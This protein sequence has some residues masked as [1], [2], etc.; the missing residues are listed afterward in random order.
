[1]GDIALVSLRATE[2]ELGPIKWGKRKKTIHVSQ[3]AVS[4]GNLIG[5]YVTIYI[6]HLIVSVQSDSSP[7]WSTAKLV[8]NGF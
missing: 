7:I 5:L 6:G 3:R 4:S 1:M 2:T 8:S